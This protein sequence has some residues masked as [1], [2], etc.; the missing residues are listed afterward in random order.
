MKRL[1]LLM[2]LLMSICTLKAQT[3]KYHTNSFSYKYCENGS[4]TD[5][6]PW[7]KSDI[8]IVLNLDRKIFNIYSEDRQDYDIYEY[9][10]EE[11]DSD[12]GSSIKFQCVNEDGLRCQVRLRIQK[13]RSRQLYVDFNDIIWVYGLK[14]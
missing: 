3:Y 11:T 4:W 14:D 1:L 10:G 5:W 13:D 12:G 2:T 8:L 6:S 7:V 9:S